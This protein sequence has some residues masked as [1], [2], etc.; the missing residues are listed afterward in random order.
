MVSNMLTHQNKNTNNNFVSVF[1]QGM[2]QIL[3]PI[4]SVEITGPDEFQGTVMGQLNKRHSILT[5]TDN[6]EGWFTI[7][8][9]VCGG[10]F[11]KSF[12]ITFL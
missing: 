1:D 4:M 9:E 2:W 12:L 6:H 8:A 7:F 5:G 10:D 11:N 3:E